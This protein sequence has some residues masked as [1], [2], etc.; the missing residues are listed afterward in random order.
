V[1]AAPAVAHPANADAQPILAMLHRNEF[2]YSALR[3]G[4][5]TDRSTDH[6]G[7]YNLKSFPVIC[8]RSGQRGH[9][10]STTSMISIHATY[11]SPAAEA[12]YSTPPS[13]AS[14]DSPTLFGTGAISFCE[15]FIKQFHTVEELEVLSDVEHIQR[16]TI[17]AQQRAN[18]VEIAR[19]LAS[20]N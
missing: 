5:I 20:V 4:E 6:P 2:V 9:K 12:T 13:A 17:R 15:Q 3:R 14:G 10:A 18:V 16:T 8:V 11:G 1:F 19:A 7:I